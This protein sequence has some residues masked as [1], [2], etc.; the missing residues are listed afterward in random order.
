MPGNLFFYIFFTCLVYVC[1]CLLLGGS[2]PGLC[3]VCVCVCFLLGGS[4]PGLCKVSV[5]V[6]VCGCVGGRARARIKK[7]WQYVTV[8]LYVYITVMYN[9]VRACI[10]KYVCI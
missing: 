8:W 2:G 4:G 3:K 6:C 1:V 9:E 5:C 7:R 10:M